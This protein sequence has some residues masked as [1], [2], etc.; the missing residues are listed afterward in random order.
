VLNALFMRHSWLVHRRYSDG[1][2][3]KAFAWSIMYL[4]LLFVALLA[5]HY[6]MPLVA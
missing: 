4:A 1:V 3:R 5:D 6:L 2:A